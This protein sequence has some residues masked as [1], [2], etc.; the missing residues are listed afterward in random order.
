MKR[1]ENS[2]IM[3]TTQINKPSKEM[4]LYNF[5]TDNQNNAILSNITTP[6]IKKSNNPTRKPNNERAVII[7]YIDQYNKI[8]AN[9]ELYHQYYESALNKEIEKHNQYFTDLIKVIEN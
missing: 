9:L 2:I 1:F 8:I 6:N 3:N 4:H 5:S 7:Y